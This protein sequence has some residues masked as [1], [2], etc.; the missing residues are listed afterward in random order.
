MNI[1][2]I[3]LEQ[4]AKALQLSI[5]QEVFRSFF[6]DRSMK[7]VWQRDTNKPL[8]LRARLSYDHGPITHT[9]LRDT[10]LEPVQ[11]WCIQNKCGRRTS[12]EQFRFRNEQEV[13]MF[14][15]KWG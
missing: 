3:V 4:A 5:D 1:Q 7:I 9:G 12:F 10:H 6:D 14:L 2:E 13:T 15:L 8:V 11:E